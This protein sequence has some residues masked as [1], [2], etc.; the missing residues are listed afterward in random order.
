VTESVR[1]VVLMWVS[2]ILFLRN[3]MPCLYVWN[4]GAASEEH[5]QE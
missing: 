2:C 3:G 5:E 1:E 4:A